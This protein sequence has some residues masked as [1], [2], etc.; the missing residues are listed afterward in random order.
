MLDRAVGHVT[1]I[2]RIGTGVT[3]LVL[4]AFG[5]L[6]AGFSGLQINLI[7]SNNELKTKYVEQ[8][9]ELQQLRT[10]LSG[11]ASKLGE[12]PKM[13]QATSDEI[14]STNVRLVQ[15]TDRL[16]SSTKKVEQA[17][18]EIG[19]LKTSVD[20]LANKVDRIEIA[21]GKIRTDLDAIA[22]GQKPPP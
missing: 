13:L 17:S 11:F 21:V 22:A 15:V 16:D 7:T 3:A 2:S 4:G 1:S 14:S 18:A 9:V 20:A 6:L 8:T 12:A 19:T 5:A 10:D